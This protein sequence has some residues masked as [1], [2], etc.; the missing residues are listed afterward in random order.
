[1]QQMLEGGNSQINPPKRQ[2]SERELIEI[3]DKRFI[4]TLHSMRENQQ[5][6]EA[7]VRSIL[8]GLQSKQPVYNFMRELEDIKATYERALEES[9]VSLKTLEQSKA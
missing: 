3:E 6:K 1:M 2:A 7:E 8:V 5:N 9:N 4:Q